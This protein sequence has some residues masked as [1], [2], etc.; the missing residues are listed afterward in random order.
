MND[1]VA[2]SPI[3]R[4]INSS[5]NPRKPVAVL[6][7]IKEAGLLHEL[8]GAKHV[9]KLLATYLAL[10]WQLSRFRRCRLHFAF[11]I[12]NSYPT[13]IPQKVPLN[14]Q[15]SVSELYCPSKWRVTPCTMLSLHRRTLI[16]SFRIRRPYTH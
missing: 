1:F 13:D 4:D 14:C 12:W 7:S 3:E 8:N 16:L 5:A 11:P 9:A 10:L 15:S 2:T 6:T